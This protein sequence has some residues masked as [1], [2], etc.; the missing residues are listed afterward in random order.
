[1]L[2]PAYH[3]ILQVILCLTFLHIS[4]AADEWELVEEI[5]G[6][7]VFESAWEG[8]SEHQYKGIRA[9]QQ[10]VEI[11]A[12][13]LADINSYPSWFY[14]CTEAKKISNNDTSVLD[15]SLYIVIDVPWPFSD[16]DAVFHAVTAVDHDSEKVVIRSKARPESE[17]VLHKNHVRIT[18]S[19]QLW[20]LEKIAPHKTQVTFI[21]RTAVSGSMAAFISDMGS[22]ATVLQSMLNMPSV[23]AHPRYKKLG[24]ELKKRFD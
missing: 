18:N 12:A 1:M 3:M 20:V 23:A 9:F 14:R 15:F 11:I 21:N 10:P 17:V 19:E 4:F 8:Y 2:N 22:Q 6:V 7:K 5:D 13:V 16:R 24:A